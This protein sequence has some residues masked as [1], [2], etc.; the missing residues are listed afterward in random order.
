MLRDEPEDAALFASAFGL[1][2]SARPT[3]VP[4]GPSSQQSAAGASTGRPAGAVEDSSALWCCRCNRWFS[5]VGCAR[6]PAVGHTC[7]PHSHLRST[8]GRPPTASHARS[9]VPKWRFCHPRCACELMGVRVTAGVIVCLVRIT[10]RRRDRLRSGPGPRRC[11]RGGR[12]AGPREA[13]PDD[14]WRRDLGRGLRCVLR[15]DARHRLEGPAGGP[16]PRAR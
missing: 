2:P 12:R 14:S 15:G 1:V 5:G 16:A 9:V 4:A 10:C 3:E 8:Q 11:L 13:P 6:W 7:C